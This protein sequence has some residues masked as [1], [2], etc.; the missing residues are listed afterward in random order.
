MPWCCQIDLNPIPPRIMSAT[1]VNV[2]VA[3]V[4]GTSDI[5][6]NLRALETMTADAAAKGADIV[7]FPEAMMYQFTASAEALSSAAKTHGHLFESRMAEIAARH[8]IAIVAGTYSSGQG[9]L[10]RNMLT[11]MDANG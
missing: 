2:A 6:K 11:A 5:D 10:A 8:R 7:L 1:S 3:Q 9:A 4:T